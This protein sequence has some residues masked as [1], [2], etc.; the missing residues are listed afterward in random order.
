MQFS[1]EDEIETP[2]LARNPVKITTQKITTTEYYENEQS[3]SQSPMKSLEQIIP[4]QTTVNEF[5]ATE[6]ENEG[7]HVD[8]IQEAYKSNNNQSQNHS[9]VRNYTN[10]PPRTTWGQE[11]SSA[12]TSFTDNEMQLDQSMNTTNGH[13][14]GNSNGHPQK[15]KSVP[16]KSLN[17]A[18]KRRSFARLS[19]GHELANTTQQNYDRQYLDETHFE[20]NVSEKETTPNLL[21]KQKEKDSKTSEIEA[22]PRNSSFSRFLSVLPK[23]F[24]AV[25]VIIVFMFL[26]S[27]NPP[28]PPNTL[29]CN[30]AD[31]GNCMNREELDEASGS[32]LNKIHKQLNEVA[33]LDAC[34]ET[35]QSPKMN[36]VDLVQTL[37][38]DTTSKIIDSVL[39]QFFRHPNYGVALFDGDDK[40]VKHED[41]IERQ[42]VNSLLIAEPT[43]EHDKCRFRKM[44]LRVL[45]TIWSEKVKFYL[46][47][48]FGMVLV[49]K[50]I[51]KR[52]ETKKEAGK[53]VN[54]F[55]EEILDF[56]ENRDYSATHL[57]DQLIQIDDRPKL[58][59]LWNKALQKIKENETRVVF[60]QEMLNGEYVEMLSWAMPG[61]QTNG[62]S[63]NSEASFSRNVQKP[64]SA[65]WAGA[66]LGNKKPI[67]KAPQN[68]CA[69]KIRD[70]Y[71]SERL[72]ATEAGRVELKNEII[73]QT[74]L[75][76]R[77]NGKDG[78]NP[79]HY[80]TFVN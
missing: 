52:M 19:A 30:S 46:S 57:R 2:L 45:E 79:V 10:T 59:K 66:A 78:L 27:G 37:P 8:D 76:M 25:F 31:P 35:T 64:F 29:T 28:S 12:Y 4:P 15:D 65:R 73:G 36:L 22:T 55:V 33:M 75:L 43:S 17:Y 70:F 69:L 58:L 47:M 1:S 26:F 60:R 44:K 61:T 41:Q 68:C 14:N 18:R 20:N 40:Q 6:D 3:K 16:D 39:I 7:D 34:G 53:K 74:N 77:V 13:Q 49:G 80:R 50:F 54:E 51:G 42:M 56:V 71:D 67:D 62:C 63:N 21:Q 38:Y 72:V 32:A 5:S 48:F 11:M 24:F 23:I 9:P